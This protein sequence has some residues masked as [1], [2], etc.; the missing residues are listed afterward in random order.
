MLIERLVGA[1]GTFK[2]VYV[3][4]H[5][6]EFGLR[7]FEEGVQGPADRRMATVQSQPELA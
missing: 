7:V 5:V 1:F 2:Q 4:M 3:E 6:D